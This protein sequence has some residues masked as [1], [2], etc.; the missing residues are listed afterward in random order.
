MGGHAILCPTVKVGIQI[1]GSDATTGNLA[2]VPGSHGQAVHYRWAERAADVPVV[3][4]DTAPGDV[5][6][7]VQDLV[8]ASPRPTGAG[9]RRTM[10]VSHYPPRLWQHI[11][12]GQAFNDLIRNRTEQVARLA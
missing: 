6:V 4:I 10:Y 11:G 9:G 8:H 3:H 12:P 1:T 2:V 7:H 5:T